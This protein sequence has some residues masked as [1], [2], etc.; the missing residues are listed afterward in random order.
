MTAEALLAQGYTVYH[1]ARRLDQMDDLKAKG[2]HPLRMDVVDD[3]SVQA[4]VKRIIDE[5]GRI[6]VLINNAG[7]AVYG[8]IESVDLELARRQFEVN[9]FGVARLT[10]TLLPHMRRQTS[11]HIINISSVVGK[12]SGSVLGWYAASKHSVEAISDALRVEV[13]SFGIRVAMIEPGRSEPSSRASR[14]SSS[15]RF[16]TTRRTER[17]S[18]TSRTTSSRHTKKPQRPNRS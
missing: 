14:S 6:D 11:G 13:E 3:A 10:R 7:Y 8:M 15:I 9:V 18:R 4:G 5:Q 2:A 1:A 12:V 16:N 17:A